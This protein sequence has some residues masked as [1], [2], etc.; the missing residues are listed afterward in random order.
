VD[1]VFNK[2]FSTLVSSQSCP[3]SASY[4]TLIL[5]FPKWSPPSSCSP[6]PWSNSP[7]RSSYLL[8]LLTRQQKNLLIQNQIKDSSTSS[9][10]FRKR[11]NHNHKVHL[12][13][14]LVNY[15]WFHI[16][17]F[18]VPQIKAIQET[19]L[20]IDSK[21]DEMDR[22]LKSLSNNFNKYQLTY[23]LSVRRAVSDERGLSYARSFTVKNLEG[24]ARIFGSRNSCQSF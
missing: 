3:S 12:L 14:Y 22:E 1:D 10:C 8:W 4:P 13:F 21:I 17:D 9:N 7:P 15:F 19:L 18:L 11:S 23:E 24:L 6:H 2:Y 16:I 5:F 20:K